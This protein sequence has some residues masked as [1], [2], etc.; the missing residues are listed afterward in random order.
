MLSY[1][2]AALPAPTSAPARLL[3]LQCALR[4]S[5]AGKVSIPTGLVRGMRLGAGATA[6]AELQ[7]VQWLYT[8][9][10]PRPGSEGFTA[11]LLD[12]ALRTQAP[13]RG[14][15]ARAADW[16]IRTCRVKTLH[17]LGSL[18]RLLALA[19]AAHPPAGASEEESS[20]DQA[21]LARMCGLAPQS[22]L[23]TLALL[24]DTHF[25]Q[26]WAHDLTHEE[27]R[28]KLALPEQPSPGHRPETPPQSAHHPTAGAAADRENGPSAAR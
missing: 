5:A 14:D 28:W 25:L 6:L 11:H 27:V 26:S 1:L 23:H 22:L 24:A 16:S 2:A 3:A 15:R 12:V 18:P 17:Q 4:S 19:L 8:T 10:P 7:E 9:V 21:H 13:A 20:A